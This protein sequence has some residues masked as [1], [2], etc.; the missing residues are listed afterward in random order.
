M[1]LGLIAIQDGG[2]TILLNEMLDEAVD[3]LLGCEDEGEIHLMG[4]I[5]PFMRNDLKRNANFYEVLVPLYSVSEFRSQ[6][7]MTRT[8]FEALSR[9]VAATGSIPRGNRF[10]RKPTPIDKQ[11]LT[12][13]WFISNM[14]SMRSV[15][16]RFNVTLSSL[17]RIIKRVSE[18]VITLREEYIKWPNGTF[19]LDFLLS[20]CCQIKEG[21]C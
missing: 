3:E 8:T 5:T 13:I 1:S 10:G 2:E 12:F 7:Q 9:E 11:V 18:A 6:F 14:E 20:E 4:S 21:I 19:R 15:P 17:E 16:D